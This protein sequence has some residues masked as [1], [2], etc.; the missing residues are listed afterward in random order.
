MQPT[1][2]Q[3]NMTITHADNIIYNPFAYINIL[4]N[5]HKPLIICVF[6]KGFHQLIIK[7]CSVCMQ[8]KFTIYNLII[9]I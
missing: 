1:I 5:V 3:V 8:L 2:Q 6:T 9:Y 7:K 4:E